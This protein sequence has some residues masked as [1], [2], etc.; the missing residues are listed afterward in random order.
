[1]LYNFDTNYIIYLIKL[2]VKKLKKI[3]D[4]IEL[5]PKS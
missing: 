3:A 5:N 1:M 4:K 2:L